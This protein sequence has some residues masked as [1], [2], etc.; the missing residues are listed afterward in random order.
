MCEAT[1]SSEHVDFSVW[2]LTCI[3]RM[4]S[5]P[6][7]LSALVITPLQLQQVL[8]SEDISALK[9]PN[10]LCIAFC[11]F[12]CKQYKLQQ[13]SECAIVCVPSP[14]RIPLECWEAP[15]KALF[16]SGAGEEEPVQVMDRGETETFTHT[17][18]ERVKHY[19]AVIAAL[20]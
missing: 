9:A 13:S 14:A 19:S 7:T 3:G 6:P 15:T 8:Y 16:T 5:L 4:G 1:G 12:S 10:C 2:L 17:K 18:T 11:I 20:G